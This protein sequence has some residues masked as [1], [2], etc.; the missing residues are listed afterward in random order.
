MVTVQESKGYFY[1]VGAGDF[2]GYAFPTRRDAEEVLAAIKSDQD[3]HSGPD[4][5]C[6]SGIASDLDTNGGLDEGTGMG[7]LV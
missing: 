1:I 7:E 2:Y 4:L 5:F 6:W 3:R